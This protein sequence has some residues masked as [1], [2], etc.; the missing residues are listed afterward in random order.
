M[1][2]EWPCVNHTPSLLCF[3]SVVLAGCGTVGRIAHTILWYEEVTFVVAG[4]TL[5]DVPGME[6]AA[7]G[8]IN[9]CLTHTPP[10]P[11]PA[12]RT[13][14]GPAQ[15]YR[16][17]STIVKPRLPFLGG[18]GFRAQVLPTPIWSPHTRAALGFTLQRSR[19]M[20]YN[21][22]VGLGSRCPHSLWRPEIAS[23]SW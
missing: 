19:L 8:V 6:L 14:P 4:I 10:L 21:G 2:L 15:N 11:E 13:C 18:R 12:P 3:Y 17:N 22:L 7:L 1:N 20:H 16:L 23:S 5:Q 9:W